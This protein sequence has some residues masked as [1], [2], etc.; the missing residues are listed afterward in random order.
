MNREAASYF[1]LVFTDDREIAEREK[2]KSQIATGGTDYAVGNASATIDRTYDGR[3]ADP[4]DEVLLKEVWTGNKDA[5]TILFRSY[6]RL[7]RTVA[8]RI[9]RNEAEADDLVQEV[10]LFIFRKA[11]LFDAARGNARS[12]IVQV[13]YHRAIDRR[14][15]LASRHFYKGEALDDRMLS[16]T[17]VVHYEESMEGKLGR[18]TL[19]EIE[20]ALSEDQHRVLDLYFYEGF[21]LSEIA[22]A[23]G[24]TVGNIRNHYYR[25][26][27]KMRRHILGA[28]SRAG[29]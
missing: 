10:F 21:A 13:T 9:L 25:G 1:Q 29:E 27:E 14:R 28:K 20:E 22:E 26:L 16:D 4:T 24:Q 3:V 17:S 5:L 6:A 23:M 19:R 8:C 2:K 7:V 11:D 18:A 12:W 15:Y